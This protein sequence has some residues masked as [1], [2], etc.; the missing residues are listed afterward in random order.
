MNI[1][2]RTQ[3]KRHGLVTFCLMLLVLLALVCSFPQSAKA[4]P[5]DDAANF[6]NNIFSVNQQ[7]GVEEDYYALLWEGDQTLALTVVEN[8]SN[9]STLALKPYDEDNESQKFYIQSNG[10]DGYVLYSASGTTTSQAVDV[11]DGSFTIDGS[12]QT[13]SANNST[14]Q[15]FLL[16]LNKNG[17][18]SVTTQGQTAFALGVND[19]S[20]GETVGLQARGSSLQG[21]EDSNV[22]WMLKEARVPGMEYTEAA[23]GDKI[24]YSITQEVNT[25]GVNAFVRYQEMNIHDTLPDGLNYISARLLNEAGVDITQSAGSMSYNSD[26]RE[27]KFT[28]SSG[29]LANYMELNGESYTLEITAE[30]AEIPESQK[31]DNVGYTTINDTTLTSNKVT[32]PIKPSELVVDKTSDKTQYAATDQVTFTINVTQK[33]TNAAVND[34]VITDTIPDGFTYVSNSMKVT[35]S[36]GLNVTSKFENNTFTINVDRMRVGDQ[37]TLVF[38]CNIEEEVKGADVTNTAQAYGK[39]Y[40]VVEDTTTVNIL[41]P[42]HYYVDGSTQPVYVDESGQPGQ[43]YK[44]PDAATQAG[45]KTNCTRFDGWYLDKECTIPYDPNTNGIYGGGFDLYGRNVVT[46]N[47]APTNNSYFKQHPEK[48]Y[49]L[50][51]SMTTA[52]TNNSQILPT[53]KEF[54]WGTT[55]TFEKGKS[56]WFKDMGQAREMVPSDGV[57]GNPSGTGTPQKTAVLTSDTTAYIEWQGATYDGVY[58]E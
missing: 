53:S 27:V 37:V 7:S 31:F 48:D 38:T 19:G 51:E 34:V 13:W 41:A 39:G 29:Y 36:S 16:Q 14:N 49:Y 1:G 35:N 12:I 2:F 21:S 17:S 50:N 58:R 30:I 10:N 47:Y 28:F 56:L 18:Y 22:Q 52:F 45:T 42:V 57:F 26:T 24:V 15:S 4:N 54:Y 5:I 8:G 40:E 11:K 9:G 25:L 43:I 46:L 33:N 44:V 55:V 23:I 3:N 20:D 32:T 6:F